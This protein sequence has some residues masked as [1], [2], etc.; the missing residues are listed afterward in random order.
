MSRAAGAVGHH[1]LPEDLSSLIGRE[2][3]Q[4]EVV[5]LL[6]AHRVVSLVGVGGVGK[7]RLALA[8]ARSAMVEFPGGIWLAELGA[9]TD[10]RLVAGVV[11]ASVGVVV[12]PRQPVVESLATGIGSTRVLLVLDNCEHL[13]QTCAELVESLVSACSRLH[14]LAT[15]RE[16][17][18]LPGEIAW[19]VSPLA[20]PVDALAPLEQL[21][22]V[23]SVRLFV[24]R[25]QAASRSFSLTAANA[26]AVGQVCHS[27]DGLPLALE[28]AAAGVRVLSPQQ[29]TVRL[30]D[31]FKLLVRGSRTAPLRQQTLESAVAW[32]YDL[33]QPEDKRLFD[34]LSTFAGGFSLEAV[35]AVCGLESSNVLDSLARLVDQS[36][37][38]AGS[39]ER[40]ERR[41]NLLETLSAYAGDRLRE[42]GEQALVRER[43]KAWVL[44]QA[45]QAGAALRGPDQARWLRWAEREH[46]TMRSALDWA[47]SSGDSD[48]ALRVVGA[49]WWSWLLHDRWSEA[50]EWLERAL[51]MPGGEPHTS[52]RARVLQGAGTTAGLRGHYAQ[53]QAHISEC[54]AI[55]HELNDDDLLLAGHSAQ[56]LLF[57]QQGESDAAQSHVEAMLESARHLHRP[58]YEARA[59]EFVASRALR[60]GDFS[61][62]ADQLNRA[63]ELART[64]GDAWNVAMLLGQLGDVE[65][66]RGTH[67]RAA[68]LYHESIRLFQSLGLR[69]DPSRVH[70]LGYVALAQREPGRA[71]VLFVDALRAFRHVGD[72]R[73]IADCLI[74]LGCVRAAERRPAE[75]ARLFGAG[76]AALEAVGS[77]VWPSNRADYQHWERIARAAVGTHAWSE[78]WSLGRGLGVETIVDELLLQVKPSATLVTTRQLSPVA[79]LTSRER[80]VTELAARG[81]SNRRIA[82]TL[83]IA[84]K[85]AANH[86]QNALDKLDVHSRSELAARAVELGLLS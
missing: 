14:V 1:N 66:M 15:S 76:D 16:P 43:L 71:A 31:R 3:D 62:A 56:A 18:G 35:E 82:E 61:A 65:R 53:A 17:L 73:G 41:Y 72:Q 29:L 23:D 7:T 60:S 52:L 36:L 48:T 11:A 80:E 85:T 10:G 83:V 13:V 64:A 39:D 37:V 46:D 9:I 20:T 74:G 51:S 45:E 49:L 42:R 4:A 77:V 22:Q 25:A 2:R 19:Q 44:V 55:A 26:A 58:W 34:W 81:L 50:H 27:L 57:Q 30:D 21:A 59:A 78:A 63:L 8:V 79:E 24:E 68:P 6:A 38:V 32:S 12:R 33:L 28:L 47:I 84:E 67:S 40:G 70:N 69:E 75:A 86:L 5:G 54:L